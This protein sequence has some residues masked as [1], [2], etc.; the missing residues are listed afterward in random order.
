MPYSE[1]IKA[2]A[3]TKKSSQDQLQSKNKLLRISFLNNIV[4]ISIEDFLKYLCASKNLD[5]EFKFSDFNNI[6]QEVSKQNS[7]VVNN[8]IDIIIIMLKLENISRNL[9][10]RFCSLSKKDISDER[11]YILNFVESTLS[12]IRKKSN[13]M[14]IFHLFE[15]PE[16]PAYGILDTQSENYHLGTIKGINNSLLDLKHHFNN[17]YFINNDF[18]LKRIK[19]D[20]IYDNRYW[21]IGQAPYSNSALR[22]FSIEQFKFIQS[23]LGMNKKCLVLDCDNTL[24]GGVIGEDGL[25]NIAI[26]TEYPGSCY[27]EFQEEILNLYHRGIILALNSKNNEN[28]VWN[29]FEK[30]P[31][32]LLKKEHFSSWRINW[33][34]KADNI[35]SI[36]EELNI[37]IESMVFF[38]D[39]EFEIN[40]IAKK[41][42]EITTIHAPENA[43]D[44]RKSINECGL[45]DSLIFSD[46]DRKRTERYR[47]ESLRKEYNRK[48][49]NLE[50]YLKS[51]E[52]ELSITLADD[53]LIPRLSQLTKRTNQFNLTTKRYSES[54]ISFFHKSASWDILSLSYKDRFGESGL[55]GLLILNYLGKEAV[56]DSFLLSCR[57]IG[58]GV[59]EAFLSS[60]LLFLEKKNINKVACHY[61][62]TEK[63]TLVENFFDNRMFNLISKTDALKKY[64]YNIN[65]REI[66]IPPYFHRVILN[67]VTV[68][69]Q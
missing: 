66:M 20:D 8:E 56:I 18:V 6:Y 4:A 46:E 65:F 14:V 62:R 52:I 50:D 22:E 49:D 16:Y 61:E 40:L 42:P 19:R 30:H 33:Q 15:T 57:I 58:R 35:L 29:V 31:N 24:W 26:G 12:E 28:D 48:F 23:Y 36:A 67:G 17:L 37:G 47:A 39:S 53:S 59:E 41:L 43:S 21:H 25:T 10:R 54:E 45:F 9:A 64:S 69:E 68:Y 27:L 7:Q 60:C 1:I 3:K 34:N 38:D 5:V 51:L 55:T 13:A 11:H 63:N 32:M 44:Y 2:L